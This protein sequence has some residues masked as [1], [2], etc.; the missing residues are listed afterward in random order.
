[1]AGAAAPRK[2][3]LFPEKLPVGELHDR[4]PPR[5]YAASH[6]RF[7]DCEPDHGGACRNLQRYPPVF[8]RGLY[9]GNLILSGKQHSRIFPVPAFDLFIYG[10]VNA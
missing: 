4:K 1:M 10:I 6:G 5:A 3:G 9:G 2:Y 7:P 8:Q